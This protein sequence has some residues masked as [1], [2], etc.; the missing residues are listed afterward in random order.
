MLPEALTLMAGIPVDEA[1]MLPTVMLPEEFI[2]MAGVA[3]VD[4]AVM[5]PTVMLLFGEVDISETVEANIAA[6]SVKPDAAENIKPEF[7]VSD[8]F[9]AMGFVLVFVF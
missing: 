7:V 1:L 8:I 3:D 2:F 6:A 4:E 9:K 5:L